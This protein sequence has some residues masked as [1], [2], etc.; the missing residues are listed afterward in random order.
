MV[1]CSDARD[2]GL[3]RR[4]ALCAA[5][6]GRPPDMREIADPPLPH[7]HRPR[8]RARRTTS[9]SGSTRCTRPT[10]ARLR[11][12]KADGRPMPRFEV[13]LFRTPDDYLALHRRAH[14]AT[15]AASSC[16]AA[17]CWP[18]SSRARAATRSAARS[19]TRRSTSSPTPSSAPTCPCGSTRGWRRCSRRRS[20]PATASASGRCPP[21]RI[22]QLQDDLP[23]KRLIDFETLMGLAPDGVGQAAG[24]RPRH[25]ARRSTTRRGRWSTS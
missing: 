3:L 6:R 23:T 4:A 8:S 22:R 7:P 18:R 5:R 16:P 20:G 25:A 9:P 14:A 19:S 10:P 15:P 1:R 21:R 2:P 17:T 24:D 13:Y 11:L 12:F